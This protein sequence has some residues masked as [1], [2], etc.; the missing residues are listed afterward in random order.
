MQDL[1]PEN[2]SDFLRLL[3]VSVVNVPSDTQSSTL[4]RVIKA[5]IGLGVGGVLITNV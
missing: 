1:N 3:I 5:L 2:S 4:I